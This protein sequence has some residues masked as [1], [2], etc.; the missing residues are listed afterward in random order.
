MKIIPSSFRDR[1]Q[2][3]KMSNASFTIP[4]TKIR[5]APVVT[6]SH[7][8]HHAPPLG[9]NRVNSLSGLSCAYIS[10]SPVSLYP[11]HNNKAVSPQHIPVNLNY[12][13]HST[14]CDQHNVPPSTKLQYPR[15]PLPRLRHYSAQYPNNC[16]MRLPTSES[17]PHLRSPTHGH[18][19]MRPKNGHAAAN[20]RTC[21]SAHG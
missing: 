20:Q 15:K 10:P 9:T 18:S 12:L 5:E 11:L 17:R 8:T 16:N 3:D 6:P 13:N 1:P 4:S 2:Y 21:R 7:Q 14:V 19:T